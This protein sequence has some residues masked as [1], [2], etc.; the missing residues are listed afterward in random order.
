MF[1]SFRKLFLP[2]MILLAAC[3]PVVTEQLLRPGGR[4]GLPDRPYVHPIARNSGYIF[5]GTVQSVKQISPR[6][7][8]V[9]TV[10]ISFHVDEAIRGVRTGQTLVIREWAGLWNTGERY[11]RG[12]RVLLFLYL[13]SKLG[14]TSPVGGTMGRFAVGPRGRV[15]VPRGRIGS[16]PWS[17]NRDGLM[18]GEMEFTPR[19]LVR[20]LRS[21]EGE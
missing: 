15:I 12:E 4:Q 10:Q 16:L 8:S 7:S 18:P 3:N 13:P 2:G 11:R 17:R 1:S 20:M 14:L 9:A 21:A 6:T 5:A 19:K